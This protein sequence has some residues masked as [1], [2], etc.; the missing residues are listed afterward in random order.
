MTASVFA[1]YDPEA[2]AL[3]VYLMPRGTVVDHTDEIDFGRI[4]DF[5]AAGRVIGELRLVGLFTGSAYASRAEEVPYLRRKIV[6]VLNRAGLDPTSHAGRSLV[7]VLETYPRDELFQ[8]DPGLL[9]RFALAIV[10]LALFAATV[11]A[12]A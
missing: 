2:D 5:D 9:L 3:Y 4:V 8:I 1:T 11:M 12:L 10:S 7:H 6:A